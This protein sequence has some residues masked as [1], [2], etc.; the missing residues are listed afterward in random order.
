[1]AAIVIKPLKIKYSVDCIRVNFIDTIAKSMRLP[2]Q[3]VKTQN[4][5]TIDFMHVGAS[6]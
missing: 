2:T 6:V 1:M 3:V 4:A 5:F